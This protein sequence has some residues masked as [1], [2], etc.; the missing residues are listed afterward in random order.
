MKGT[1]FGVDVETKSVNV[2][3]F[4]DNIHNHYHCPQTQKCAEAMRKNRE[5][6]QI[7]NQQGQIISQQGQ[8][9]SQKDQIISQQNKANQNLQDQL[10]QS[11]HRNEKNMETV[12]I[13]AKEVQARG[14]RI[15]KLEKEN[16]EYKERERKEREKKKKQEK[17]GGGDLFL[18][19]DEP[20]LQD[21]IDNSQPS[22]QDFL[23]DPWCQRL[24]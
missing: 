12:N 24:N 16:R 22:I 2:N 3:M 11:T 17:R 23:N 6:Q 20:S 10:T 14:D 7:I 5:F 8:G 18:G 1:L 13:L 15:N 21:L 4:G 19:G 9:L